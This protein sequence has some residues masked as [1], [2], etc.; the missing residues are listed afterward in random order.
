MQI[1]A[2]GELF[3]DSLENTGG[4]AKKYLLKNVALPLG[5]FAV[6]AGGILKFFLSEKNPSSQKDPEEE[7]GHESWFEKALPFIIA[8]VQPLI[9]NN[10]YRL[11]DRD[12]DDDDE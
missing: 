2:T 1:K 8:F 12:P 7:A 11:F 6:G 10:L 4:H 3:T 5:L 9:I